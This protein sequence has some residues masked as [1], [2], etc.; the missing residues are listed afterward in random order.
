MTMTLDRNDPQHGRLAAMNAHGNQGM[1]ADHAIGV[2]GS[3]EITLTHAKLF[4]VGITR[5][6]DSIELI[7]NDRNRVASA[8]T[9]HVGE[10]ESAIE[11]VG[12][13]TRPSPTQAVKNA[14]AGPNAPAPAPSPS[15]RHLNARC[16][17][18]SSS[19]AAT[20]SRNS[21]CDADVFVCSVIGERTL[22]GV[23]QRG[24]RSA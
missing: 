9:R 16:R 23:T 3:S 17:S 19:E 10:K 22:N 18:P 7:V 1:T 20:A 21:A 11:T 14:T 6:R 13:I 4:L 2:I 5:S 24:S 8:I 12:D 15:P